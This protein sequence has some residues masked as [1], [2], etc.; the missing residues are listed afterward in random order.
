MHGDDRAAV[1][2]GTVL[3]LFSEKTE[4]SYRVG[5]VGIERICREANEFDVPDDKGKVFFS[6]QFVD[7][8][9]TIADYVMVTDQSDIRD[10]ELRQDIDSPLVLFLHA[11]LGIVSSVYDEID[12][13]FFSIYMFY[14]IFCLIVATLGIAHQD[15]A[16]RVF[17]FCCCLDKRDVVVVDIAFGN[18]EP[19]VLRMVIDQITCRQEYA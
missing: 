17:I 9:V 10:I 2:P 16:D 6:E 3:Q 13:V 7:N 12:A 14:E 5:G 1:M 15:E 18:G 4:I 11:E 19:A 8:L